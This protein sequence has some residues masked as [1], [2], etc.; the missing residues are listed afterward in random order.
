VEGGEPVTTDVAIVP[1]VLDVRSVSLR[2]GP[3]LILDRISFSVPRG[4]LVAIMGPSGSGKTTMLRVIAALDRFDEG[5][6]AVDGMAVS[7]GAPIPRPAL[8]ELR[9]RVGMVFQ[10]HHLFEHLTVLKN[11]T[12]AP[13]HARGVAPAAA[14]A[15]AHELLRALDVE[16]RA[17]ALPRELSG[18]ESQR[19]AIARA[20]AVDPPVLMLDEPTA[21]LD[22]Q[23]RAEL[24]ALL[25]RLAEQ[26]R[27]ILVSTHDEAFARSWATAV[28][29]LRDG[30]V[31]EASAEGGDT[32]R[33]AASGE[34]RAAPRVP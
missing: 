20:L 18:G 11:V 10:F 6:I 9:R 16:Q 24:G 14:Q 2:R 33:G 8:R 27:A 30:A 34:C 32:S 12:L 25:R 22:S 1:D 29:R 26:G 4:G 7:G 31:T 17:G 19:V 21:S 23:R 15:R 5:T 28:L 3:R 13:M